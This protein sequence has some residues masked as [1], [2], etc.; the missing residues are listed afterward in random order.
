M[1][2]NK[3]ALQVSP[4][5]KNHSAESWAVSYA[6][7]LMVLLSFFIVFYSFDEKSVL[8]NVVVSISKTTGGAVDSNKTGAMGGDV[9]DGIFNHKVL[10]EV[11]AMFRDA[12]VEAVVSKERIVV[13]LPDNIYPIGGYKVP[14]EKL[15]AILKSLEKYQAELSI[16]V[17]G[18]ADG[19]GFQNKTRVVKDNLTLSSMRAAYASSHIQEVLPQAQVWIQAS[20][21]SKRKTRSISFVIEPRKSGAL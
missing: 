20:D 5:G 18:H 6:D 2:P 14:A 1:R 16:T 10:T 3:R 15:D 17:M 12:K 8:H 13:D 9:P 11:S 21:D 4:A 19:V 7:F